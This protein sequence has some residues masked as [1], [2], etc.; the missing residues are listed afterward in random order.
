MAG[1]SGADEMLLR[2]HSCGA[3]IY[4]EHLDKKMAGFRSGKLL[5]VHCTREQNGPSP[6]DAEP[7]AE[8]PAAPATPTENDLAPISLVDALEAPEAP[9]QK[10]SHGT[11]SVPAVAPT[12]ELKLTR[13]VN[14]TGTGATRC[15]TFH[16]KL[17]DEAMRHMDMQI[18]EWCDRHPE[19]EIKFCST[20]VGIWTGKHAEPNLIVTVFY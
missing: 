19:V 11:M 12:E 5:C 13:A 9:A 14:K 8:A 2:C 7:A 6:A 16:S 3:S 17:S 18:N 15:H 20:T 1:P 4:K 10:T